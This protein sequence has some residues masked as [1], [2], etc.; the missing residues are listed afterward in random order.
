MNEKKLKLGIVGLGHLGK[1]HLKCAKDLAEI[2]IVGIYDVDLNTA[3]ETSEKFEVPQFDD[4]NRLI[5]QV[6]AIDI[7]SPTTTHFEIA[8]L[9]LS[10]GKHLFVEKPVV[11]SLDEAQ[12]L[13]SMERGSGL[14][15]QVGHVERFNPAFLAIKKRH[16]NPLFIE[17]HRL[18]AF[19]PRGN[20]VPVILDL[21]I[22][23]LDIILQLVPSEVEHI[24]ASGVCVVNSTPDISNV[25]IEFKNGTVANV[26]ASRLAMN[27][28]RKMRI[29]QK[30]AYIS[31]DFLEKQTQMI[32][33]ENP[34]ADNQCQGLELLTQDGKKCLHMEML[35]SPS[36]NA[37][38]E[39]LRSFAH[40]VLYQSPIAVTLMD[41][42]RALKLAQTILDQIELKNEK[43]ASVIL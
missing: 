25:R 37:I 24:Y 4:L 14:V 39:E 28:M 42:I 11:S 41:G 15:I 1:I 9:A 35:E 3:R 27:N 13:L 40:A 20:D 36:I 16:V 38:Q 18:A 2:E 34:D 29:F 33:L 32:R 43:L 10:L 31:M 7:V 17:A 22:H 8:K 26:T 6:D 12:E 19:N 21:M 5:N 23:D 30:D